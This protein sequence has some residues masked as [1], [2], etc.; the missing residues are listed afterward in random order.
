MKYLLPLKINTSHSYTA[1]LDNKQIKIGFNLINDEWHISIENICNN[2]KIVYGLDDLLA[3]LNIDIKLI[4]EGNKSEVI[5]Q[6]YFDNPNNKLILVIGS[7]AL[8]Q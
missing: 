2:L 5:G 8:L 7:K 4:L 6:D 3:F 1:I